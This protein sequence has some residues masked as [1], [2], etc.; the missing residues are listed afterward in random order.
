MKLQIMD[1]SWS[2]LDL[3]VF[4]TLHPA[5]CLRIRE[6]MTANEAC[7][8]WPVRSCQESR[9]SRREVSGSFS[10]FSLCGCLELC[11]KTKG[12]CC[13]HGHLF[14]GLFLVSASGNLSPRA[15]SPGVLAVLLPP[16]LGPCATLCGFPEVCP[17]F[18]IRFFVCVCVCVCVCFL[19]N[20]FL[21]LLF[22]AGCVTD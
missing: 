4:T 11:L 22:C 13:S 5:V 2:L 16:V 8:S 10:W 20:Y 15:F 9:E 18:A 17:H 7:A 19:L 6:R 14:H 3:C 12:H 21:N 1:S